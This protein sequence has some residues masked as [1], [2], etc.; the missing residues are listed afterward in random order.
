LTTIL[1]SPSVRV[2]ALTPKNLVTQLTAI[3][4]SGPQGR[5][6]STREKAEAQISDFG[7]LS[8][9][10]ATLQDAAKVLTD[11]EGM[12]SKTASYTDSTALV[13]VELDTDVQAGSYNFEVNAIAQSQSLTSA[14]F[15][16]KDDAVGEGTL[17]FSFGNVTADVDGVITAFAQDLE[18]DSVEITIDSTNNS[19]E[20]LRDAI[21]KADFGVQ[22]VIV[23]DGG[24]FRLQLNAA[25]GANNELEVRVAEAGGSP[26]NADASG[27]SRFA[28][29]LDEPGASQLVQ[30]Q[31]G[32]D[33]ELTINGLAVTRESNNIDDIVQGLKFDVLKASPGEIVTITVSDDKA[34]AE[35]NIRA[36]VEAF[37]LFLDAI[38]PAVGRYEQEDEDGKKTTV[39]GSLANDALAK[40]V[41]SRIRSLISGA[42]PGL[43][44]SNFTSLAGI[45]I[46]TE[47]SG[48]L[49][50]DEDSFSDAFA[51]NFSD[52][53]KLFAPQTSGSSSDISINSY[54]D[55]TIAGEY[56]VVITTPPSRGAYQGGAIDAGVVF[57][58]FDSSAKVYT[59]TVEVDGKTSAELTLPGA[60]YAS[61]SD[62]AAALQTLINADET[63]SAASADVTVSYD[64][65]NNRFDLISNSYGTNSNVSIKSPSNAIADDLGLAEA[66]GTPGVKVVGTVN[67]VAGFGSAN[68]LLPALGEPGAGLAMII[69]ENATSGTVNFSRGFAG[70][71]ASVLDEFLLNNGLIDIREDNL[72]KTIDKADDDE[73]NL[74]RRMTAYQDRL[75]NQFIAMERIISGLNSSGSFLDNLIESLPFT[76]SNK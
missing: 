60:T 41:V 23:N 12:F 57:P 39:T 36:F 11:P 18:E 50:I 48:K 20:G 33:A 27:L 38:K 31:G 25:S 66:T 14:V 74:D 6:D 29:N 43:A 49:S 34:F 28:F 3:E 26:T 68:V 62:L 1:F 58:D 61:Q 7:L 37:N 70:E 47:L 56:D 15:T 71:L 55:G 16:N 69:G 45:G 42:V 8:N 30:N 46:R 2:P 21:N 13:P 75:M 19:L 32:Q 72:N 24:G 54:N 4:R 5:I 53:Q 65:D 63:L 44:D 76:S 40:S 10:M 17:T 52:V 35:D 59:F 9:A 22:A 67:G 51:D 64:S 73:K